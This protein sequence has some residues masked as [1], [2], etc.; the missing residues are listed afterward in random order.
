MGYGRPKTHLRQVQTYVEHH[1]QERISVAEM[2]KTMGLT[3]SYL[4]ACF[5]AQTGESV[6]AFIRRRKAERAKQLL[7]MPEYS[8][9][10]VC[11]MLGYFDQSHFTRAFKAE[12]GQT[13]GEYRADGLRAAV[14][15]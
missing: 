7:L 15:P 14:D 10:Q 1:L 9:T 2:A 3:A 11:G 6:T 12:T 4:N 13:P 8:I 5:R